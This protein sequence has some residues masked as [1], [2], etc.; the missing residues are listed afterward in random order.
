MKLGDV[1]RAER[2]ALAIL[3]D[4]NRTTGALRG[5]YVFEV[6]G[7]VRDAVHCGIQGALNIYEPLEDEPTPEAGRDATTERPE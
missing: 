3:D 4:W 7:I 5:S 1:E 2:R 6:E